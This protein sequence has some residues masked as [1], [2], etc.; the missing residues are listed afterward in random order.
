[1]KRAI[2]SKTESRRRGFSI[3]YVLLATV[4]VVGLIT[5]LLVTALATSKKVVSTGDY[6]DRK[7]FLD[8]SAQ[9]FIKE[10]EGGTLNANALK[11]ELDQNEFGVEF[12]ID[13]LEMSALFNREVI[14]QVQ[15]TRGDEGLKLVVYRYLYL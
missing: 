1:M 7:A 5:T 4:L 9:K 10:V 14:L 3:E 12:Y 6:I 11:T 8:V 13:P 15:F 2:I